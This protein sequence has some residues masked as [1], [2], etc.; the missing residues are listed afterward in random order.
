MFGHTTELSNSNSQRTLANARLYGQARPKPPHVRLSGGL[1]SGLIFTGKTG[2][3]PVFPATSANKWTPGTYGKYEGPGTHTRDW[4]D[5][6][7]LLRP[8]T[9]LHTFPQ[10]CYGSSSVRSDVQLREEDKPKAKPK[11][12]RN[13][14]IIGLVE[15]SK[16]IRSLSMKPDEREKLQSSRL[17]QARGAG[18]SPLNQARWRLGGRL[19]ASASAPALGNQRAAT[20]SS[21]SLMGGSS[22]PFFLP[23]SPVS[24]IVQTNASQPVPMARAPFTVR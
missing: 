4:S 14:S 24:R 17:N 1:G 11:R 12:N 5:P 13:L 10:T 2:N 21:A 23:R 16:D 6:A 20:A 15:S 9:E 7:L 19:G 22:M 8:S 18:A 3:L